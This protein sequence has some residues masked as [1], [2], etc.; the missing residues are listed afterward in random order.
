MLIMSNLERH[1]KSGMFLETTCR[2]SSATIYKSDEL[3]DTSAPE[4]VYFS[5]RG[6]NMITPEILKVLFYE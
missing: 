3:E 4:V 1:T 2:D 6:P 5:S